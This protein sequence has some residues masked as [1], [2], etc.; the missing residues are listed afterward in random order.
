MAGGDNGKIIIWNWEKNFAIEHVLAPPKFIFDL[1]RYVMS[2]SMNYFNSDIVVS[3][4][5]NGAIMVW[6]IPFKELSEYRNKDN[7][8]FIKRSSKLLETF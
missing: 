4:Y 8:S 5:L 7:T 3:G 1:Y 6:N 2:M